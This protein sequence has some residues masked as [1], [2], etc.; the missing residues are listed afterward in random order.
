MN[1]QMAED[2]FD[3]PSTWL[4]SVLNQEGFRLT[5]QRQ[6][7]LELFNPLE[8]EQHLT[9][10][11]IRQRLL[12]QGD[13]ISF[14]TIYRALHVMVN[15]GLLRELDLAEDK[16]CYELSQPFINHHHLICVQCGAIKEFDDEMIVQASAKEA[17]S[18]AYALLNSQF[19]IYG[20]CGDCWPL[21][22]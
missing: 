7:I 1:S 21:Q 5:N 14:S 8:K 2:Q 22:R 3:R 15:L 17:R 20:L 9:A 6:K 4:K 10:E 19:T 16:K 13:R 18:H 11:E 12:E